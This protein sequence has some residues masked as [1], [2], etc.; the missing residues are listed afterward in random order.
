MPT[1]AV[2]P[3]KGG[4][5]YG[6]AVVFNIAC[7]GRVVTLERSPEGGPQ[8]LPIACVDER[9]ER[10][11][12][13]DYVFAVSRV[14]AYDDRTNLN[15]KV[16]GAKVDGVPVPIT[17]A[18]PVELERCTE[19]S[20]D[21]CK[22]I[23]IDIDIAPESWESDPNNVGP[24]GQIGREQIWVT[25]Y[26]DIGDFDNDARLLFDTKSGRVDKSEV[27]FRAPT[28]P[29]NGTIWAVIHDNRA[30]AEWVVFPVRVK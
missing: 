29:M 14:Y 20:K 30:G 5:P 13:S 2:T 6:L 7:A 9:G 4:P 23:K 24:D 10:V 11:P 8:Q 26:S 1:D 21:K 17:G 19:S 22:E 3:R 27:V 15:P 25:Y 18:A 28:T 12:P 16:L